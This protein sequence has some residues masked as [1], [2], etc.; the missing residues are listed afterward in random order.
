MEGPRPLEPLQPIVEPILPVTKVNPIV[1][2]GGDNVTKDLNQQML[3]HDEERQATLYLQLSSPKALTL[4]SDKH[5]DLMTELL[6]NF[7]YQLYEER[8]GQGLYGKIDYSLPASAQ[9]FVVTS[10]NLAGQLKAQKIKI[11][12]LNL[13]AVTL[14]ECFALIINHATV[15]FDYYVQASIRLKELLITND[16]KQVINFDELL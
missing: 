5:R 16:V 3:A 10:I 8:S 12:E 6:A 14:I 2:S 13:S 9:T 11:K 1:A 7:P 4:A 15:D